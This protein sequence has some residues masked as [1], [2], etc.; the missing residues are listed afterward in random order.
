MPALAGWLRRVAAAL[1]AALVLAG[2]GGSGAQPAAAPAIPA[3]L[4]RG[5][6]TIGP[7]LRFH[8]PATGP[9]LG[10][11]KRG[12]GSRIGVHVELFAANHVLLIAAGIGAQPPLRLTAGRIVG[13]RCYGELVTLDPTGVVFVRPGPPLALGALFQSWGQPLSST[14]LASFSA[15]PGGRVAVF[16]GGRPWRGLPER[17][18]LTRHAEIVLEVG[19]HVPPHTSYTFPPVP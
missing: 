11:C 18:P 3:A 15:G 2:C 19:P 10:R 8:P 7:G 16:I 14:R 12:L 6:R 13:A 4:L 17:V 5:M 9:V 1:G